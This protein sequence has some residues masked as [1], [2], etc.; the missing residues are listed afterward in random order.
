MME[1]RHVRQLL[2][3]THTNDSTSQGRLRRTSLLIGAVALL[4]GSARCF[5]SNGQDCGSVVRGCV[6]IFNNINRNLSV[7]AT[8]PGTVVNLPAAIFY[9]AIDEGLGSVAVDSAV[10]ASTVFSIVDGGTTG[11]TVTCTVSSTA[12]ASSNPWLLVESTLD[13]GVGLTCLKW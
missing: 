5:P 8:P 4:L 12:W 7:S 13:G 6:D 10:D 3:G 11:S 1:C 2:G 9:S